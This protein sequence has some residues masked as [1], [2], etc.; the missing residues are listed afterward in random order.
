MKFLVITRDPDVAVA[1]KE[2]LTPYECHCMPDWR[3]AL[4]CCAGYDLIFVDQLATLEKAHEVAGYEKFAMAKME[5]PKASEIPLILIS[6]PADYEM[7]FVI[8]WP[9]FVL[10]NIQRPV[11]AKMFRRAS[12][13]I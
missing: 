6:T 2:G 9:D 13:W 12:T 8:G 10:S 3:E 11:T 5:H 7:D 4:E 1:A